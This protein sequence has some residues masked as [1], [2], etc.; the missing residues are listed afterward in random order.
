M[1]DQ[2]FKSFREESRKNYGVT[3]EE[4]V[5]SNDDLQI[6]ALLRIADS[7]EIM[8]KDRVKLENDNK[9]LRDR[10]KQLNQEIESLKRQSA[11]YKGKFN[12]LKNKEV[13]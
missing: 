11:A 7:M 10:I 12:N 1:S 4:R 6:G 13:K 2:K 3:S 5:V 8:C 9:Y